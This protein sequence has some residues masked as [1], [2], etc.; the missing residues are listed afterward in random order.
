MEH[1]TALSTFFEQLGKAALEAKTQAEQGNHD[2][3]LTLLRHIA[4][5]IRYD[6]NDVERAAYLELRPKGEVKV[7]DITKAGV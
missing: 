6:W 5:K 3:A 2:T 7:G 4:Q 1:L